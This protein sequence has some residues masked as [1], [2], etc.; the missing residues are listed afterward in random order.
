[1][2]RNLATVLS[3]FVLLGTV[4]CGEDDEGGVVVITASSYAGRD[5]CDWHA[6]WWQWALA[7]PSDTNPQT[8]ATGAHCSAGQ[9]DDDVYFL[10][11]NASGSPVR[12]SAIQPFFS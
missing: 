2:I 8:D 5:I 7:A 6:D 10:A 9:T 4:G 3:A 11:G 1:M 12:W